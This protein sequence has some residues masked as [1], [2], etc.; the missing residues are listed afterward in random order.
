MVPARDLDRSDQEYR[1]YGYS[2][3]AAG[4]FAA[5]LDVGDPEQAVI[6][7]EQARGVLLS[8]ALETRGDV[9]DLAARYPAV[10]AEFTAVRESLSVDPPTGEEPAE[11]VGRSRRE[12]ARAW[13]HVLE[14]IRQLPS[15]ARFLL[16]PTLEE[17]LEGTA[18]G[19]IILL[20]TTENRSD[21]V[22]L[23]TSGILHVPLRDLT[24][25]RLHEQ[26]RAFATARE[27]VERPGVSF[28]DNYEANQAMGR[29]LGWM[30]DAAAAP[31]LDA[32]VRA[33]DETRRVWWVPVGELAFLPWHA[34]GHHDRRTDRPAPT[35]LDRVVSSYTPTLRAMSHLRTRAPDRALTAGPVLVGLA[36]TPGATPLYGVHAEIAH[37]ATLMPQ[38]VVLRDAGATRDGVL[39]QL[40]HATL[41]HFA[42]HGVSVPNRP[43]SSRLLM[44]D[45]AERPLTVLDIARLHLQNAQLAFLS[46]CSTAQASAGL[47]DE[48][49]HITSAF[50][51]AGFPHVI[52]TL[53]TIGDLAAV[54]LTKRVYQGLSGDPAR[55]LHAAVLE[56][57]DRDPDRPSR[58]AAHVHVGV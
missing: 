16:P 28:V 32:L 31:V 9:T 51:L 52:G 27:T 54:E 23:R 12:R 50:Q 10:A 14:R 35:V 15:F 7:L 1:L 40:P 25:T 47:T 24:W 11:A 30:W 22:V 43:S 6:L 42:C 46:A 45:H 21:A 2:G 57:R 56:A 48:V 36:E 34:A 13:Q 5:A 19:P 37:L 20:S 55:A 38:A 33:G 39:D 26:A 29:V 17:L 4:A 49:I 44:Y 53:W 58:W 18:E 41:V 3:L 8:Q